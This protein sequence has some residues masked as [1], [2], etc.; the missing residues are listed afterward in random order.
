MNTEVFRVCG[1]LYA[2][3]PVQNEWTGNYKLNIRKVRMGDTG[4][5]VCVDGQHVNV[6]YQ[7]KELKMYEDKVDMWRDWYKK[8][9]R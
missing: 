8:T 4:Y 2:C 1:D 7:V 6:D 9:A 5:Y 3:V